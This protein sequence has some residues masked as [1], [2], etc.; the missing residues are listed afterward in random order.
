MSA[1]PSRTRARVG[2]RFSRVLSSAAT[3]VL[4]VTLVPI[5]AVSAVVV[6]NPSDDAYV[7]AASPSSNYGAAST[8]RVGR[9]NSKDTRSYLKFSVT[10]LAGEASVTLRLFVAD[11]SAE[12]STLYR[13]ANTSWSESTIT[14]KTRPALGTSALSSASAVSTGTWIELPAGMLPGNGTYSFALTST[15]SNAAWFSSSEGASPPQLVVTPLSAETPTPTP[16]PDPTPEPTPASEPTPEPT[17]EPTL[18]PTPEPTPTP[19]PDATP[20][21]TADEPT[22][23]AGNTYYVGP[24]GSDL[25]VGTIDSPFRTVAHGLRTVR[26]GDTVVLRGGD[27]VEDFDIDPADGTATDRITVRAYAGERPVI[28]GLI[29]L[30]DADYMTLDGIN[31]TWNTGRYDQHMVSMSGGTGWIWQNSELWGARGFANLL[32][33]GAP[34]NWTVRRNAIH[35]TYGGEENVN[36]SHNIYA[37]TGLAAGSGLIERNLLFN[38]DHGA[39]LKLAGPGGGVGG[40]ANVTVRYNTLYN[41]TKPIV[42]SDLSTN[43]LVER[44]IIGYSRVDALIRLY[45][46]TGTGNVV[47]DNIGFNSAKLR[48][49]NDYDS[50]LLCPNVADASNVYPLD[51]LFDAT[52]INGFHPQNPAAHAYGRYADGN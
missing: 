31:V 52:D 49:C 15:S 32:I 14:W 39:N 21:P 20:T 8:L 33:G 41:A 26:A 43:N 23:P 7:R 35:D 42:I 51:P 4:L 17:P 12:L 9:T 28:H 48:L 10:G 6:V 46:L 24:T 22:A 47:R 3:A 38:A 36:R 29:R 40:A 27:Y 11:P 2:P 37:N 1:S 44:N 5:G 45:Q 16:T 34:S 25:N 50:T 13:V 30:R 18:T 19:T